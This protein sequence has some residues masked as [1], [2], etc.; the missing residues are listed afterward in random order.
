[1]VIENGILVRVQ[2]SD[3]I[4][5]EFEVP[6]GV[7]EIGEGAFLEC[8]S[9][10]EITIPESVT[11]IGR[12]AF[13][14]C[15]SLTQVNIPENVTKI[16]VSAFSECKNLEKILIKNSKTNEIEELNLLQVCERFGDGAF[17]IK[18]VDSELGNFK[19][20]N[21]NVFLTN[22][23]IEKM[24]EKGYIKPELSEEE[25]ERQAQILKDRIQNIFKKS[26]F[27]LSENYNQAYEVHYI[28]K[29]I[30]VIGLDETEKMLEI[31]QTI[32]K[33][34]ME[35]YSENLLKVYEPR[36]TVKGDLP[37]VFSLLDC[38][39]QNIEPKDRQN[40][41][42]SLNKNVE[43]SKNTKELMSKIAEETGLSIDERIIQKVTKQIN[44]RRYNE[45][46]EYVEGK[47]RELIQGEN[48]HHIGIV[49]GLVK[50]VIKKNI[51]EGDN[52]L[53]L[54][55]LLKEELAKERENS[56]TGEIERVYGL[57]IQAQKE[58]ILRVIEKVYED[59]EISENVVD[60]LKRNKDQ[61]WIQKFTQI[62]GQV[63]S[64]EDITREEKEKIEEQLREK[65]IKGKYETDKR[66][67]IREEVDKE[68]VF[69]LLSE[70]RCEDILTYEKA[71]MIFSG[72][73]EPYSE[74]FGSWFIANK[75]EIIKNP[76]YYSKI[77]TIHND[78]EYI[79]STGKGSTMTLFKN[80]NLSVEQAIKIQE[81]RILQGREGNEEYYKKVNTVDISEREAREGED[82]FE[83]VK[84]REGSYIPNV[85][86]E[87]KRY[88][89]RMLRVDD[90]MNIL[91]GNATNCC[92]R[93]GDVG[94]GAMEHAAT[95]K[96]GRIFVVEEIDEDG[97]VK[98][99]VAQ[100]WVWRNKDTMC[101]DNIEVPE[102]DKPLLKT[103]VDEK[104]I[105]TQKEIL[106]IYQDAAK[107]VIEKDRKIVG[108]VLEKRVKEGKITEEEYEKLY[109]T[110]ALKQVTVGYGYNDLGILKKELE[111]VDEE[112]LVS[113][114]A[115]D[116]EGISDPW[117]DSGIRIDAQEVGQMGGNDGG[118][119]YLARYKDENGNI[120]K[121]EKV[122]NA[123]E[124]PEIEDIGVEYLYKKERERI[125]EKG[126][127]IDEGMIKSVVEIENIAYREGQK[128]LQ[129]AETY[130]DIADRYGI[131]PDN[132]QIQ[133]SREKDWYMIYE[134]REGEIYI[135]DAAMINGANSEN[136][137]KVS[138]ETM[139]AT[140]QMAEAM[141]E[142][143]YKASKEGKKVRFEA[144]E[145]TSYVNMKKLV[146]DGTIEIE[147]DD[148]RKWEESRYRYYDDWDEDE[149][150]QSNKEEIMMHDM[151]ITV[152]E[153][154][155]KEKLEEMK[156][157]R[158]KLRQRKETK[159]PESPE[160]R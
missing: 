101:F 142:L 149:E 109:E 40:F 99:I 138:N 144:T 82:I 52:S 128:L 126:R 3:I 39:E 119:L 7:T 141:Y 49:E 59:Q 53:S 45:K 113:P 158:E 139:E 9:L 34:D 61:R 79:L 135:A 25:K 43:E 58:G 98:S 4:G 156:I 127:E 18:N 22:L 112:E 111:E 1:M 60:V 19:I 85:E 159:L 90:A 68:E 133:V 110:L 10:T 151:L 80:G 114:R 16:E 51:V 17:D 12:D 122:N 15:S 124:S 153:E 86:V 81:N 28:T 77:S 91:V 24:I 5:G 31:P 75:E 50:N 64:L 115:K 160:N 84:K 47:I 94:K 63:G 74:E 71:E 35:Q 129:K 106:K 116:F 42:M 100:S 72:M 132:M 54:E 118:Q 41:Y 66:Y 37:A 70:S 147:E 26:H 125:K 67:R 76:K 155:I 32:N 29:M 140:T 123:D 89:G 56:Q 88:R 97:E 130:E 87:T 2:N 120:V 57:G 20:I 62:K 143:M 137:G 92:Q 93:V 145:D 21:D 23:N 30:D 104:S 96:N 33:S 121:G 95:A 44:Q 83:V 11:E 103:G 152:D 46:E 117:I 13:Y 107:N 136:K 38:V 27:S 73:N 131:E 69:K 146:K 78:F 108:K 14:R 102:S 105:E 157:L 148:V 36:Y 48:L 154:K 134:E 8:S 150:I 65:E 55:E 6:E